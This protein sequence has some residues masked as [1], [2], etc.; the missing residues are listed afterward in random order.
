MN[1]KLRMVNKKLGIFGD[2]ANVR[3]GPLGTPASGTFLAIF[4]CAKARAQVEQ[5]IYFHV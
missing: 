3:S 2:N 4:S 5:L 1:V